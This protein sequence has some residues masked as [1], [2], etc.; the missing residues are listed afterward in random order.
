MRPASR[1]GSR[2][3]TSSTPD[4]TFP[5]SAVAV[6]AEL[7]ITHGAAF[8][9]QAVCS[10]F[11]YALATADAL[12]KS[13][14]HRLHVERGAVGDAKFRL[15]R[16]R[17]G[18]KGIVR[19]RGREQDEIDRLRIEV[20]MRQRCTRRLR[21]HLR[22][23]FPGRGDA[24]LM[25]AGALHDPFVGRVDLARELGVGEDLTRQIAAAAEHD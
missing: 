8:D 3:F 18:G 10:G 13:G 25:D 15:Y 7:G 9:V 21:G 5:A 12:L 14:A 17:A 6:Q 16:D 2:P 24:T 19:R 1:T 22:R 23:H 4:N 20:R 11:L